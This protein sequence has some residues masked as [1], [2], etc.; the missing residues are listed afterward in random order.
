MGLGQTVYPQ[1]LVESSVCYPL[2]GP[3]NLDPDMALDSN[4]P[5]TKC[6]DGMPWKTHHFR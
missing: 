6:I 1:Q 4:G 5:S 3:L 2:V